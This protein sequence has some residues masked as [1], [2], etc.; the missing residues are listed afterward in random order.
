VDGR[1]NINETALERCRIP[2]FI[3]GGQGHCET[4]GVIAAWFDRH[5]CQAA[6]V[7][8]DH[9]VYCTVF[10]LGSLEEIVRGLQKRIGFGGFASAREASPELTP[11]PIVNP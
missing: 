11:V 8:P 3:L 4:D 10:E 6:I 7:R 5:Q 9:Y 2:Q 1:K